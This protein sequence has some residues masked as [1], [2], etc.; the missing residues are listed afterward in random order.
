M[1]WL[2]AHIWN[3]ILSKFEQSKIGCNQGLDCFLF[4]SNIKP[5]TIWENANKQLERM[6][7]G[8]CPDMTCVYAVFTWNEHS[9]PSFIPV[10]WVGFCVVIRLLCSTAQEHIH[11]T[12]S[13]T[14][15]SHLDWVSVVRY[16]GTSWK[17]QPLL[18]RFV[19]STWTKHYFCVADHDFSS[20]CSHTHWLMY[21]CAG[22]TV[23]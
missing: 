7:A 17:S 11:G 2:W 18:L 10:Q 4:M 12:V 23:P 3:L 13:D 21:M 16:C 9:I 20:V 14:N 15:C 6:K 5:K 8:G 19:F 22:S 1:N